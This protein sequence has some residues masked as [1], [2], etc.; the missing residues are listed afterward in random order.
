MFYKILMS[1]LITILVHF[2]VLNW[3]CY[4]NTGVLHDCSCENTKV[5]VVTITRR[6][7]ALLPILGTLCFFLSCMIKMVTSKL[8]CILHSNLHLIHSDI[9]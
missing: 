5:I 2:S 1:I 4:N 8:D 3:E 7:Y 6:L 9:F